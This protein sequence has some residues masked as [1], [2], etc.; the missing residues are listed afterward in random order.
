MLNGLR[1]A[2]ESVDVEEREDGLEITR[3]EQEQT[4]REASADD[5]CVNVK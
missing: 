3:L 1:R 2:R 4:R 5:L